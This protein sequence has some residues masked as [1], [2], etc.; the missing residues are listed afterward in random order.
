MRT[1]PIK[2]VLHSLR[3]MSSGVQKPVT[4]RLKPADRSTWRPSYVTGNLFSCPEDEALAHC[5]SEDCRMGA[6]IAVMFRKKFQG[7]VE[8][9]EQKKLTGQCA[10]LKRGRRFVYYLITKKKATQ[11][12]TY[13][14]L[15]RSLED[16]KSHCVLNEVTRISMP[17]IGCGLDRLKWDRVSVI[18][19]Q[20]F[21]HTN[22]SVTVYS[23]PERAE[24]KVMNENARR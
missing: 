12:P 22:I 18:L 11:K 20:V 1:H 7:Q 6:G 8:L 10:V 24:T 21:R 23:L 14:S 17:R 3:T 9:K 13:D 5:I 4:H 16:M 2:Q 19:E 15:Q